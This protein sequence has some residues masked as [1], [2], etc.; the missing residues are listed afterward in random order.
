MTGTDP[1]RRQRWV[2]LVVG[3]MAGVMLVLGMA[4]CCAWSARRLALRPAAAATATA[5]PAPTGTDTPSGPEAP[6]KKPK[7]TPKPT[8]TPRFARPIKK[9]GPE[10]YMGTN[11]DL[12]HPPVVKVRNVTREYVGELRKSLGP[13]TLIVVRFEGDEPKPEQEARQAARD[14]YGRH[15]DEMLAMRDLGAPNVAF[16]TAANEVANQ[17][18]D[19]FVQF[20][21]EL[22]PLM[23]G[24][25]LRCVAGNPAVGNWNEKLWPK[26]APV[27]KI[28]KPDDFLGVHEYWSDEADIDNRWHCARWSI[29]EIAAV[30]GNVKIVVTECGHDSAG[31]GGPTGWRDAISEEQYLV[32][33]EKY[34]ALLRQ[35]PNVVGAT[36]FSIDSNWP[37]FNVYDLWPDVVYRYSLTP[38]PTP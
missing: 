14:W 11:R 34:D 31:G 23:H 2:V 30:I 1:G 8:S 16:E 18:L 17:D 3:A 27:L 4:A 35:F 5:S 32:E 9:I 7:K 38:T 22:I 28:L 13:D 21:L 33:L 37:E 36:A 10:I 15:R 12:G 29:P 6:T 24:D 26:F 20:S 19:W 25:G